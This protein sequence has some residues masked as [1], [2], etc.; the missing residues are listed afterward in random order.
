MGLHT[1]SNGCYNAKLTKPKHV[2]ILE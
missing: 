2:V 1:T